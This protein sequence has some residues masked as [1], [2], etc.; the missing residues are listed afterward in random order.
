MYAIIFSVILMIVVMGVRFKIEQPSTH[1]FRYKGSIFSVSNDVYKV[2]S[3]AQ[4]IS[5]EQK[6]RV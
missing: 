6:I 1:I 3:E 2:S 4:N 5:L